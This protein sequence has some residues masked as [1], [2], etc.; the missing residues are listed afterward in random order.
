MLVF[1]K[2]TNDVNHNHFRDRNRFNSF[3]LQAL[4]DC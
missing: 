3:I 4:I 1:I 2:E